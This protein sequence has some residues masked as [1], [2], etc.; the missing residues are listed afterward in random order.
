MTFYYS[1]RPKLSTSKQLSNSTIKLLIITST[2]TEIGKQTN[3]KQKTKEP[4]RK[5]SLYLMTLTRSMIQVIAANAET[6]A[7]TAAEIKH[8]A[9][10]L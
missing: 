9:N 4:S 6:P 10:Y 5:K 7:M 1:Y 2:L 3:K 8:M